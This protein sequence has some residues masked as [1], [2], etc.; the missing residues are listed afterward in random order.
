MRSTCEPA[1][2]DFR[3]CLP[4][5]ITL[6]NATVS[7]AEFRLVRAFAVSTGDSMSGDMRIFPIAKGACYEEV[8]LRGKSLGEDQLA[9]SVLSIEFKSK[10]TNFTWV[11]SHISPTQR[12]PPYLLQKTIP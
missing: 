3:S 6:A 1:K 7:R 2:L 4:F 5:R 8:F 9:F 11:P 12:A 10:F